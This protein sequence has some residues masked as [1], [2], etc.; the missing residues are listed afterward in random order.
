MT[1]IRKMWSFKFVFRSCDGQDLKR[2]LQSRRERLRKPRNLCFA[3]LRSRVSPFPVCCRSVAWIQS[4]SVEHTLEALSLVIQ[5]QFTSIFIR[6][7]DGHS[8][9][10]DLLA[11]TFGVSS[12]QHQRVAGSAVQVMNQE[13]WRVVWGDVCSDLSKRRIVAPHATKLIRE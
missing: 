1:G 9:Q 4:K 6:R 2:A 8:E 7:P 12:V 10:R 3:P 11:P 13:W 5:N